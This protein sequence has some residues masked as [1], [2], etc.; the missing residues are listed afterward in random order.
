VVSRAS[1]VRGSYFESGSLPEK[2]IK[3]IFAPLAYTYL[4]E[5]H[6][7]DDGKYYTQSFTKVKEPK[8]TAFKEKIYVNGGSFLSSIISSNLKGSGRATL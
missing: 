1:L 3:I 6:K 5:V 2:I 4:F 7:E 8:A